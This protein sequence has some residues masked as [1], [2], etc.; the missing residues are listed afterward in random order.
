[1]T[2]EGL[3]WVEEAAQAAEAAAESFRDEMD[4]SGGAARALSGAD[5]KN[6]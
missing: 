6:G 3:E 4:D 5:Q 1:M 2:A